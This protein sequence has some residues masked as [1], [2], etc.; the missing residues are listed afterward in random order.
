MMKRAFA[1]L[2]ILMLLTGCNYQT[3]DPSTPAYS[4]SVPSGNQSTDSQPTGSQANDSKP[5]DRDYVVPTVDPDFWELLCEN[6]D[7]SM[8]FDTTR[9]GHLMFW[10][11]A[12]QE[13]AGKT[14][15]ITT[16]TGHTSEVM[17]YQDGDPHPMEFSFFLM[18]QDFD[19]ESLKTDIASQTSI[20]K[21]WR[22]KYEKALSEIPAMYCYRFYIPL[23]DL[24]IDETA[25]EP[26]QLKTLTVT[27]DGQ[28]KT[29]DLGKVQF[30]PGKVPCNY[31]L[32]GG[33]EDRSFM[34]A[35][36]GSGFNKE[37]HLKV[38][39]LR[40]V[41][42]KDV[43][44]QGISFPGSEGVM[45]VSCEIVI[46][47]PFGDKYNM[48][49]DANS[50]IEVD[51]GSEIQINLVMEDPVRANTLIANT[52]RYLSLDYSRDGVTYGDYI[53]MSCSVAVD[54]YFFYEWC[55]GGVDVWKYL[56]EYKDMLNWKDYSSQE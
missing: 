44:L 6:C 35:G 9:E 4:N 39:G 48:T 25:T 38:S 34:R 49:W 21:T 47:T 51:E 37:G 3:A 20:L 14:M 32:E 33:L 16:D 36:Y 5:A 28:T 42:T 29:Y 46:T 8:Y 11:V 26:Q 24:G 12:V 10:L 31:S 41:T 56:F 27:L 13:P 52:I 45:V 2:L 55:M 23:R 54:P 22:A 18:Y 50:P 30:L 19:W 15:T 17:V 40:F 1:L 7:I 53:Y 43:V